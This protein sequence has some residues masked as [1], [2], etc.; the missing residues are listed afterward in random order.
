VRVLAER[1][2]R[3]SPHWIPASENF[4]SSIA[5]RTAA[6]I[7]GD[8]TFNLNGKYKYEYDLAEEWQ[9][10]TGLPFV[11]A[12][13]VSNKKLP[14]TFLENFNA[15]L[16]SGVSQR[17]LIISELKELDRFKIDVAEYLGRNISYELDPLKRKAMELF[18]SYLP[19]GGY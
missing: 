14:G 8:R 9:K 15:A 18:L 17:D 1:H 11:F 5:D 19:A 4:E 10:M 7:I 13:W 2:W 6:V 16:R 12:C 3:I